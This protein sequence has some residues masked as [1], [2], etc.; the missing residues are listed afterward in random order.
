[1]A[2]LQLMLDRFWCQLKIELHVNFY[3]GK[4]FITVICEKIKSIITEVLSFEYQF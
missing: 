3:P 2:N 4:Y 1:M